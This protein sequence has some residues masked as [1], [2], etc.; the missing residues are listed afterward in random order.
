MAVL[1]TEAERNALRARYYALSVKN[2]DA[3]LAGS[4]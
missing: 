3:L 2:A 1:L 4:D